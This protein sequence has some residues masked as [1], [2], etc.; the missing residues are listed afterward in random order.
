MALCEQL[1]IKRKELIM[2]ELSLNAAS[3][4]ATYGVIL[5]TGAE[6]RREFCIALVGE[7]RE[8]GAKHIDAIFDATKAAIDYERMDDAERALVRKQLQ[9]VRSIV[10]GWNKLG[11]DNQRAFVGGGLPASSAA[12]IADPKAP[13]A[14]K[15]DPAPEP[16]GAE[17]ITPQEMGVHFAA[18]L[19]SMD[20]NSLTVG[21]AK[22]VKAVADALTAFKARIGDK[23]KLPLAA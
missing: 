17:V 6:A 21:D 11:A 12:K 5:H 14:P 22:A 4:I 16:S 13:K 8:R 23:V 7:V 3:A 20:P 10:K 1:T 9:Y 19:D 2:F 18:W 15:A